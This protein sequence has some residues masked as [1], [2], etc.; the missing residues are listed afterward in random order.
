M[1]RLIARAAALTL[2]AATA[3]LGTS[4][5]PAHADSGPDINRVIGFARAQVGKPYVLG[6]NGPAAWDCSSL[7]QAAY[8]QIGVEL[9]RITSEQVGAGQWEPTSQMQPGDLLFINGADAPYPG[10]VGLYAGNGQVIEGKGRAWGVIVTPLSAWHPLAV[11]RPTAGVGVNRYLDKA[12]ADTGVPAALLRA[13][14]WQ[15]SGYSPSIRSSVGA[16]GIAQFM[17]GTWPS[18]GGDGDPLNPADAIPAQARMMAALIKANGGSVELAL[19]A[20]N[21]GQG[22]VNRFHG[23]PPASWAG[24]QTFNYV[25]NITASSGVHGHLDL[26]PQPLPLPQRVVHEA[27]RQVRTAVQPPS[28]PDSPAL[29]VHDIAV[30]MLLL[31]AILAFLSHY[32]P[33]L[34]RILRKAATPPQR[35][36]KPGVRWAAK[37]LTA[38]AVRKGE[39]GLRTVERHRNRKAF[40]R[41]RLSAAAPQPRRRAAAPRPATATATAGRRPTLGRRNTTP[42]GFAPQ[43][44]RNRSTATPRSNRNPAAAAGTPHLIVDPPHTATA[45]TANRRSHRFRWAA[46]RNAGLRLRPAAATD[47]QPATPLEPAATADRPQPATLPHTTSDPATPQPATPRPATPQP[48]IDILT[49][50]LGGDTPQPRNRTSI[51]A[52]RRPTPPRPATLQPQGAVVDSARAS[53]FRWEQHLTD[54]AYYAAL[55]VSRNIELLNHSHGPTMVALLAYMDSLSSSLT[56]G[57]KR[58]ADEV[59]RRGFNI[60]VTSRLRGAAAEFERASNSLQQA[61]NALVEHHGESFNLQVSKGAVSLNL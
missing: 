18:W 27:A 60:E 28:L 29:A 35:G 6:A 17:P 38:T 33:Q 13:Q 12:V 46:I 1:S 16:M 4:A 25:R 61:W 49:D 39:R 11:I 19:A 54:P 23:V 31:L 53:E 59:G 37:L 41:T 14:I 7:A 10:H 40:H 57:V 51:P 45:D 42:A 55:D 15:E 8:R 20:Y 34:T 26:H 43:P 32:R 48:H 52:D 50:L 21:A 47:P 9:P 30:G 2:T 44:R 24:G 3:F 36:A 5:G 56:A 22:N 58:E